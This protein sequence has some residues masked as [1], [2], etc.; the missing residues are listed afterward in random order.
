[1]AV[2]VRPAQ[3]ADWGEAKAGFTSRVIPIL[4]AVLALAWMLSVVAWHCS[5][6]HRICWCS[7]P[8]SRIWWFPIAFALRLSEAA[9]AAEEAGPDL[10]LLSQVL[11]AFEREEFSS[12]RLLQLQAQLKQQGMPPSRAIAKLNRLVDYLEIAHNFMVRVVD[13][14]DFLSTAVCSGH[15]ELAAALRTVAPLVAGIGRGIGGAGGPGRL[16]L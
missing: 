7:P 10:M 9:H 5:G 11:T 16:H 15:R 6:S 2:G 13:L 3:L 14:G 12:P 1:M 8:Q 4:A